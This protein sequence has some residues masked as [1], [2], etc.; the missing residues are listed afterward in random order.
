MNRTTFCKY[1]LDRRKGEEW[2]RRRRRRKAGTKGCV[3]LM[4]RVLDSIMRELV[5]IRESKADA[6]S[7]VNVQLR[8]RLR[9]KD[10]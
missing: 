7:R 3:K 10:W 6:I 5:A 4:P 2:R 1:T 9:A 8:E